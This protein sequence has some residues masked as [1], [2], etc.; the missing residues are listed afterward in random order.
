MY[1]YSFKSLEKNINILKKRFSL[2]GI[3]AEFE[4]EG[5]DVFDIARLRIITKS[6]NTK[7]HVKIGGV[8]AKN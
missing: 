5:S 4:A 7:L 2:V 3:K 6:N 8:E 1:L